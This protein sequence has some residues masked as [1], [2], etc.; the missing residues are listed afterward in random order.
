[1]T[2]R[3]IAVFLTLLLSGSL[4]HAGTE[5]SE[6]DQVTRMLKREV[7]V[8]KL[9]N[10]ITVI[11]MNRGVTP[12]VA[13]EISFA[14]GSSHESYDTMGA[15]HMLEHMLFK[16][17]DRVGTTN[18]R[19]EKR[20]LKKI[21]RLGNRIDAI[22]FRNPH[23]PRLPEL[24]SR[25][26]KLQKKHAR[27]VVNAPYDSIYTR[28]GGVGFNASTSRDKTG[29]YIQLPSDK[30]ELW[31]KTE[32]ERLRKPV[33]R[34]FFLERDNVME[35]RRMRYGSS[36]SGML[37]EHF[38]ATAYSAHP[39]RHPII[40]WESSI[41]SLTI[42]KISDF[43]YKNYIPSRMT[44]TLV[45]RFDQHKALGILTKYFSS[46][47]KRPE[48]A[49][50][51]VREPEQKGEK[52]FTVNFDASPLLIM[53]WHKP[54]WPAREDYIFDVAAELLGGGKS[55]RLYRELVLEK[56]LATSVSVWNGFPGARYDNLFVIYVQPAQG[57]STSEI[58]RIIYNE[59]EN[60]TKHISK[61]EAKRIQ[62][63]L[64]SDIVF[65]LDTNKGVASLLSY[66]QTVLG[67]WTYALTYMQQVRSVTPEDIQRSVKKY[68]VPSNRTVGLLKREGGK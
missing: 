62:V 25:L 57:K 31:A 48:P 66:Y 67:D 37:M 65:S 50:V 68:L 20:L 58:E 64:E 28:A 56:K 5:K 13:L 2:R 51:Q 18:Y 4:L 61:A 52:R 46:I 29:Y 15:A 14:T 45:G 42:K 1:M 6:A 12:T 30:L 26:K 40:G 17:T 34:Q 24:R 33:F 60:L 53:G 19:K 7:K 55:S 47:K 21:N 41:K 35:E 16:G 11:M 38:I 27:Y 10:G 63:S 49:P 44:I 32:S 43:Y 59:I 54:T 8:H 23:D 3:Y 22:S 39:Y 9:K 36:G